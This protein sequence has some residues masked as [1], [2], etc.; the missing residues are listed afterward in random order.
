MRRMEKDKAL[1]QRE[2]EDLHS[3]TD[4]EAKSKGGAEKQMK[5]L[6]MQV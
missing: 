3:S 6:E 5:T 2:I 4:A 1:T